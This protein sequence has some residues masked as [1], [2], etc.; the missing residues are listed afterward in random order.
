[1]DYFFDAVLI[2]PCKS[3]L[4]LIPETLKFKLIA[5]S[6][7]FVLLNS[8]SLTILP[9]AYGRGLNCNSRTSNSKVTGIADTRDIS[10]KC[11]SDAWKVTTLS[12]HDHLRVRI[13]SIAIYRIC[14]DL[15]SMNTTNT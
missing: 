10:F 2:I 6:K 14:E 15:I 5:Y 12:F 11:A 1:M 4:I 3:L 13:L 9:I 7:N 8:D